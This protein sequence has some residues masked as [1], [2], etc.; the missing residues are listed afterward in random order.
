MAEEESCNRFLWHIDINIEKAQL[1]KKKGSII[2]FQ[3][4]WRALSRTGD[5]RCTGN[6]NT[7][8]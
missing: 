2:H 5:Q 1:Y 8:E 3:R 4:V 7:T 6:Y